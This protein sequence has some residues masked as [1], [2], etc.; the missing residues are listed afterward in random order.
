MERNPAYIRFKGI[1]V[2]ATKLINLPIGIAGKPLFVQMMHQNWLMHG[3]KLNGHSVFMFSR[4]LWCTKNSIE[5]MIFRRR[6]VALSKRQIA[7]IMILKILGWLMTLSTVRQYSVSH[8]ENCSL[9]EYEFT[10]I[11]VKLFEITARSR[12][13]PWR[14]AANAMRPRC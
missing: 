11:N 5:E 1:F 10:V 3:E 4:S 6:P 13:K 9:K 2:F 7:E 14:T 8:V 12:R